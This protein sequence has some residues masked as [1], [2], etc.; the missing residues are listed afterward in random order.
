MKNFKKSLKSLEVVNYKTFTPNYLT[1][2]FSYHK[3]EIRQEKFCFNSYT[4]WLPY[5]KYFFTFKI[6]F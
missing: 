5:C 1:K 3:S 4:F 6:Y 2:N